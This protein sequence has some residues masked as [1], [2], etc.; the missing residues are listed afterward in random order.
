MPP[1]ASWQGK[2]RKKFEK[3]EGPEMSKSLTLPYLFSNYSRK[4]FNRSFILSPDW[5]RLIFAS[6]TF[7]VSWMVSWSFFKIF[8]SLI[9]KA[10]E[11]WYVVE[12]LHIGHNII[13]TVWIHI[14]WT[15]QYYI[16]TIWYG[17][18]N[19]IRLRRL[20][21]PQA[22]QKQKENEW[23]QRYEPNTVFSFLPYVRMIFIFHK[24]REQRLFAIECS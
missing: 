9:S 12:K 17:P 19:M 23:K 13:H 20:N 6:N 14:V 1:V 24:Q 10:S 7:W 16:W 18:Y 15:I 11:V 8:L 5:A 3:M 4:N 2:L 22:N 21:Q